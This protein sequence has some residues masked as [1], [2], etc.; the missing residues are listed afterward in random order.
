MA[1][2]PEA[3]TRAVALVTGVSR[4][5]GI[6]AALA[7]GLARCGWDVAT[8]LWRAY[9]QR[10]PWGS[11]PA[12]SAWL[13]DQIEAAGARTIAVEADLSLIEA[14]AQIFDAVEAALGPV[15]ALMLAHAECMESDVMTTT[16]ESFDR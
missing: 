5:N 4:R 11:D 7:V 15:T 2:S 13:R 9:D 3:Q 16:V 10:M 8:T 12:D 14:P 1:R 6:G